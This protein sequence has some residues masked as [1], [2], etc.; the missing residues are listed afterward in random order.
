MIRFWFAVCVFLAG[1][2]SA[3]T[4]TVEGT[5]FGPIPDGAGSGPG[6]YGAPRDVLF[7]LTSGGTA[8]GASVVFSA[9]HP[10]VGDVRVR[11]IAPN[12]R[13]HLVF[14]RTG[15]TTATD[16][17]SNSN[18]AAPNSYAFSDNFNTNWWTAA[19]I[20]DA[21]I[22]GA[23]LR[24]V[25]SGG[26][27]VV[28]PPAVTSF[29]DSLLGTPV[30]GT[31]ILRIEDGW[32]G[33]AG[34]V[35]G[36]IL[37]VNTT[38]VDRLVS[39]ADDAGTGSLRQAMLSSL[40][41]DRIVFEPGFFNAPRTIT[42]L[43]ALP[44]ITQ[45]LAIEGPGAHRLTVRRGDTAPDFTIFNASS[46][47]LSISGMT[48][49]N[50]RDVGGGAGLDGFG[51]GIDSLSGA[52]T[53]FDVHVQ[54]N[55]ATAGGGAAIGQ[56][57]AWISHSTFSGNS[58][59]ASSGGIQ[60]EN[61]TRPSRLANVTISGNVS[62]AIAGGIGNINSVVEIIDSTIADNRDGFPGALRTASQ[63]GGTAITR[64]RNTLLSGNATANVAVVV[65][66]GSATI[67][68]DGFNLSSDTSAVA[69]LTQATDQNNVDARLG[70]LARQGGNTPTH[71][72]RADSPAID[73][74]HRSG[75]PTD[76]RNLARA[77]DLATTPNSIDGGDIG[78]VEMQAIVVSNILDAGASSLRAAIT[79]ANTNGT[80]FDDIVFDSTVFNVQRTI[81]VATALPV[82]TTNLTLSGPGANLLE[83]HRASGA[84][85]FS[86]FRGS[87]GLVL[88]ALSGLTVSNGLVDLDAGGGVSSAGDLT[89]HGVRI[90]G[91][92]ALSF[93]GGIFLLRNADIDH[94]T[95]DSN[96]TP[97][98]GGAIYITANFDSRVRI[99]NSTITANSAGTGG[100]IAQ[101]ASGPRLV[102]EI[103]NTTIAGNTA[104]GAS[105][106]S[107]SSVAA[108]VGSS[109]TVSLRNS[110]LSSASSPNLSV[111]SESGAS[112]VVASR[113]FNLASD[114]AA[115]FLN[116]ASDQNSANAGLAPLGNN[117][118]TTP[119]HAL[120][121][122][123]QA[124]D[125]GNNAGSGAIQDQRG[126]VPR[127]VDLP[128]AN[129]LGGDGTDIGAYEAQTTPQGNT[130]FANGFEN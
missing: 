93:G 19:V 56:N 79:A 107:I 49:S 42:L 78:A 33:D 22:P 86:V 27:G 2:G 39:N 13:E 121:M 18:L 128:A 58:A 8:T 111:S 37:T 124:L 40:P 81:D 57:D 4:E 115:V 101:Y 123:S 120:L 28:N 102:L 130:V 64:L 92:S 65:D 126:N 96:S 16:A 48:I 7:V 109:T 1:L 76:Q 73:R 41:G 84:P 30:A 66:V 55:H 119:T 53:L 97:N 118:G 24:S 46:A 112:A 60:I 117:G 110:I 98:G 9:T 59:T 10:W 35:E 105:G 75:F 63:A 88:L 68:S 104:S 108:N 12:G 3:Q 82:I 106:Q 129:A 83:V 85:E 122:T 14:A 95:F 54:G 113:G 69:F 80:G 89:L 114:A 62:S 91:N 52:L 44:T 87:N 20:G 51:G 31:W 5:N 23:L 100:G 21:N 11:L 74:G 99:A 127:T 50:G 43:T 32:T 61:Q 116:Q 17:G 15:S 25:I 38:G 77:F 36:A 70:P 6:N 90:T 71:L 29:N 67:V 125:R 72:L 45:T 34:S 26:A 94:C 47:R 103:V